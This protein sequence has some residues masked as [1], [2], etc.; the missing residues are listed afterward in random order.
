M[1]HIFFLYLI[2]KIIL[3]YLQERNTKT[4]MY[5]QNEAKVQ[6]QQNQKYQQN[7]GM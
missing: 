4:K 6:Y 2:N 3:K 5:N 7:R 1:S